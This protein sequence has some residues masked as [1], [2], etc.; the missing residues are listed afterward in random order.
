VVL[1][2]PVGWVDVRSEAG[3]RAGADPQRRMTEQELRAWGFDVVHSAQGL[4]RLSA[5][6]VHGCCGFTMMRSTG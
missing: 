5:A 3:L 2:P 4:Q 6:Q 1:L